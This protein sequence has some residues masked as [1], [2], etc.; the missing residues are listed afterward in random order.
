MS[1]TQRF[2]LFLCVFLLM[3][4]VLQPVLT[5]QTHHRVVNARSE[6]S[7]YNQN[8]NLRSRGTWRRDTKR[9]DNTVNRMYFTGFNINATR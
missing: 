5:A 9:N 2:S 6:D 7:N 3:D 4:S 8:Q 1:V